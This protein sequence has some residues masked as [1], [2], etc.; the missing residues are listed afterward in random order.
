[1]IP[2]KQRI[3]IARILSDL[4]KSDKIIDQSEILLFNELQQQFGITRHD[5]LEAMYISLTQAMTEVRNLDHEAK[6]QLQ[7]ALLHTANADNQCVAREALI[8]L[9]LKY[10]LEDSDGKY[11]LLSCDTHGSY[12]EEKFIV[13]VESDEHELVNDEIRCDVEAICDKTRLWNFDFIYIPQIAER[14]QQMDACYIQDI[15]RYLRPMFD[16]RVVELIYNRLTHITTEEF[17]SELLGAQMNMPSLRY[18]EPS[19][20]I[21]FGSSIASPSVSKSETPLQHIYTEF[22][23]IRI[24]GNVI[25]EV[26]RFITDYSKFITDRE[27]VRPQ[28]QENDFKYF[29]FYKALFDFIAQADGIQLLERKMIIDLPRKSLWIGG[30]ELRLSP[31]HLTTYI[32]LLVQSINGY[33]LP[34]FRSLEQVESHTALCEE[35]TRR[36]HKIY[37]S[38]SSSSSSWEIAKT[39]NIAAYMAHIK[40]KMRTLV[41]VSPD[42]YLPTHKSI[43]GMDYYCV[44]LS[45]D[46]VYV[47]CA[48]SDSAQEIRLRDYRP[49]R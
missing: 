17:T 46:N 44:N 48:I 27:M 43:D 8:L 45:V 36:Y 10:V 6:L 21:N 34:H 49:W 29:G 24:D 20:L 30:H 22:L 1:M 33:G 11:E 26:S 39:R 40:Q 13:Y 28:L 37:A 14:L 16:D 18:A 47:R 23:R 41:H 32:L 2:R 4:I 15:I 35:L 42:M 9:A 12:I 3:A 38:L 5:C 31:T 7:E 19:L 25:E